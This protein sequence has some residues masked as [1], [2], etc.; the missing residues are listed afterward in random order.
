MKRGLYITLCVFAIVFGTVPEQLHSL[1][2]EAVGGVDSTA[3]NSEST[4]A[5]SETAPA[6][7]PEMI[8][9]G[10]FRLSGTHNDVTYS[11]SIFREPILRNRL[12]IGVKMG[13]EYLTVEAGPMLALIETPDITLKPGAVG[14]IWLSYPGILFMHATGGSTLEISPDK[15]GSFSQFNVDGEV[16]FW[17]PHIVASGNITMKN[18]TMRQRSDFLTEDSL[19]K[20]FFRGLIHTKNIPFTIQVDVGMATVQRSYIT[21]TSSGDGIESNTKSDTFTT[22]FAGIEAVFSLTPRLNAL[23]GAEMSI[24]SL[25]KE[26]FQMPDALPPFKAWA[27]LSFTF[28]SM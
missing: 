5:S 9:F 14:G 12:F 16:G 23:F 27:G 10:M 6:F 19:L 25:D 15:I 8:P 20:Y 18:F 21:Q 13:S 22:L 7:E 2:V 1:T 4:A 28:G 17:L 26:A 3:F 24:L 11:L